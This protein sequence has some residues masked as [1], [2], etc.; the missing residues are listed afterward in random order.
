LWIN[1]IDVATIAIMDTPEILD[2]G[3]MEITIADCFLNLG[4]IS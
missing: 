4:I 2:V 1:A 3:V